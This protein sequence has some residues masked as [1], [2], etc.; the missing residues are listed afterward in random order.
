MTLQL[1]EWLRELLLG[2]GGGVLGS[3]LTAALTP[4]IGR[5]WANRAARQDAVRFFLRS[6]QR[7]HRA[8]EDFA[9][10]LDP[11]HK[12]PKLT[13]A[14]MTAHAGQIT[15]STADFQANRK[16][17]LELRDNSLEAMLEATTEGVENVAAWLNRDGGIFS[18]SVSIEFETKILLS[19]Q[20]LLRN[21]ISRVDE[22]IE[23]LTAL[24]K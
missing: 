16:L 13:A 4:P 15:E 9:P 2:I 19:K 12:L 6:F 24:S 23:K 21:T 7:M 3:I 10:Y 17:L 1:S 18:N 20:T 8:L 11:G 22:A 5:W 14:V